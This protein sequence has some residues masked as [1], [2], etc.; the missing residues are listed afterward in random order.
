MYWIV[1]LLITVGL[2]DGIGNYGFKK[3]IE[4]PR[5]CHESS[6]VDARLLVTCGSGYSFTSNHAAN[7][8]GMAIFIAMTLFQGSAWALGLFLLWALVIGYA[9][10][11]VGVHF[12]LD[13]L[14]GYVLGVLCALVGIRIYRWSFK[15][16]LLFGKSIRSNNT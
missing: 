11:Y 3:T 7:H 16:D 12:P 1:A 14:A 8:M 9:Q 15:T 4:R 6:Q 10:V 13:I 5:P 2:T